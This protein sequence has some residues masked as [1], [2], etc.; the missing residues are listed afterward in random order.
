MLPRSWMRKRYGFSRRNHRPECPSVTVGT[1]VIQRRDERFPRDLLIQCRLR[2][3]DTATQSEPVSRGDVSEEPSLFSFLTPIL[4][5]D[6]L[7]RDPPQRRDCG[8]RAP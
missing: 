5:S 3:V 8:S 2:I 6:L 7:K 4:P 1:N